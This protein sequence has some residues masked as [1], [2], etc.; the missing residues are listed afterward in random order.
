MIGSET[1][2]LYSFVHVNPTASIPLMRV[3]GC[4]ITKGDTEA[5]KFGGMPKAGSGLTDE[6][7]EFF[8]F[9][10]VEI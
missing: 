9:L 2:G 4:L 7:L 1:C 8:F 3:L 6:E 10:L 5:K